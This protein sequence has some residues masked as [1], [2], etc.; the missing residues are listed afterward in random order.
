MLIPFNF[1]SRTRNART[2]KGRIVFFVAQAFTLA[3]FLL[4]TTQIASADEVRLIDGTVI[5][6][7]E[8]WE[9]AQGVWYRQ[10]G[11]TYL[12]ERARVKS[13]NRP[14]PNEE[15]AGRS[16]TARAKVVDVE[17][18]AQT[19]TVAQAVWIHL[20]GGARVEADEA[21]ETAAGVWYRRGA[22]SIFL[23]RARVER[24]EREA[25]VAVAA[26]DAARAGGRRTVRGWSTGN[27][28]IDRLIHQNGERFGVDPYLVFCVMEQESHFNSR[29]VSPKGAMGLMQLMPGTAA[30]FGVRSAFDPAQN[31]MG[32]TKYLKELL[33]RFNN[34]VELVLASY[35]A[36]EGAVMKYGHRVPPYRETRNYVR[37]ISARYG[38]TNA[39][40]RATE[41]GVAAVASPR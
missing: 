5:T 20:V 18:S 13:V 35:N 24:V 8:A 19:E 33:R 21:S 2:N 30:R 10:G 28:G 40:V 15:I 12:L 9:D 11:V 39:T 3:A 25:P 22:L 14:K 23:D 32:G 4:V 37:R 31:I 29:V 26:T 27:K 6:V 36:G 41:N 38:Q 16:G 7:D 34:R 17:S 1:K